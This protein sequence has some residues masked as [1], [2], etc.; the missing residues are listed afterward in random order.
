MGI[1]GSS[2]WK[3]RARAYFTQEN[4]SIEHI[5]KCRLP[6]GSVLAGDLRAHRVPQLP[7]F[8]R[9]GGRHKDHGRLLSPSPRTSSPRGST[10]RTTSARCARPGRVSIPRRCRATRSRNGTR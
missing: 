2:S 6:A 7:G 8:A 1:I 10:T 9:P 4:N 5:L 3:D